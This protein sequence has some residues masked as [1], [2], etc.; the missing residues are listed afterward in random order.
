MPAGL[1]A[2]SLSE[3]LN[4]LEDFWDSEVD[5][6]G[7]KMSQGWAKWFV[8][9]LPTYEPPQ[10][11]EKAED[12]KGPSNFFPDPYVSWAASEALADTVSYMPMKSIHEEIDP[13]ATIMF[14]DIR[15]FVVDIQSTR[16][17]KLFRLIWL[18]YLA[19]HIPGLHAEISKLSTDDRW[20]NALYSTDVFI[21]TLFPPRN[22][23]NNIT[24]DSIAGVI[25]GRE[26]DYRSGLDLFREWGYEILGPLE[27]IH[28]NGTGRMWERYHGDA[29]LV[30]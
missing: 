14:S 15:D 13:Y 29:E 8:S 24:S 5:R 1:R 4:S 2:S 22:S 17:K 23:S 26:R 7:E 16:A 6:I 10:P 21:S 25:V 20:C 3:K 19:L 11:P 18:E 27:S 28:A 30:R 9:G 12:S